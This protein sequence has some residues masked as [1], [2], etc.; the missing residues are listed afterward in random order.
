VQSGVG[1]VDLKCADASVTRVPDADAPSIT[2]HATHTQ[3][4]ELVFGQIDAASLVTNAADLT[5]DA[6]AVL[7]AL[8]PRLA[9]RYYGPDMF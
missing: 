8:C 9:Y 6:A 3:T 2:L 5:E 7:Q 4:I 1:N